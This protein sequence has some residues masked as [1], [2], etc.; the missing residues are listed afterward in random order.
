[1]SI[2]SLFSP[3]RLPPSFMRKN[4]KDSILCINYITIILCISTPL[5]LFFLFF[6]LFLIFFFFFSFF[7]LYIPS[8]NLAPVYSPNILLTLSVEMRGLH[9]YQPQNSASST[10]HQPFSSYKGGDLV[11]KRKATA[12]QIRSLTSIFLG[13]SLTDCHVNSTSTCIHFNTK[14]SI[15]Q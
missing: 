5:H 11:T 14:F 12:N 3:T 9:A 2:L 6:P 13:A 10:L 8:P 1:M 4:N 15:R 7:D